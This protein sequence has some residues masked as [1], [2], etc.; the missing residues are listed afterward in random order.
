[1][2]GSKMRP[3]PVILRIT[4]DLQQ[5]LENILFRRYPRGEWGTFFFF[6][7][8]RT[9]TALV[10]TVSDLF[11][12]GAD[13]LDS[14]VPI[15]RFREP[16]IVRAAM[17]AQSGQLGVG[18]IHSHPEDYGVLPSPTDNDMDNYYADYFSGFTKKSC[19][20][21][22]IFSKNK[23][24]CLAISGRGWIDGRPCNLSEYIVPGTRSTRRHH[25]P[26]ES[27]TDHFRKRFI[28]LLGQNSAERLRNSTVVIE[29]CSGTGSPAAHI[30]ARAGVG[31]FVLIDPQRLEASNVER[32]H[33]SSPSQFV[34]GDPPYKVES[35]RE[36]IKQ[37]N[38]DAEVI[39]IVGNILQDL[40][41][42]HAITGDLIIGCTDSHHGRAAL[43]ELAYRYLTPSIDVGVKLEGDAGRVTAEVGQITIYAAG[44]PCAHCLAVVNGRRVTY[45]LMSESERDERR[46]LAAA[47]RARGD[48]EGGYW[49]DFPELHTVGHLA[50][51]GGA[52]AASYAIGWLTGKFQAPDQYFQFNILAAGFDYVPVRLDRKA[53]CPCS[54]TI[55]HADQGAAYS[56]ISPPE[57][58]P[59]AFLLN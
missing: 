37:V 45:E 1:M 58:W 36:L 52:L 39:C 6:G 10:I 32:V 41:R 54:H 33:G 35:L 12:P 44:L 50:T 42:D 31:K 2:V 46:R 15:V 7:F 38:P 8:R 16:Y 20:F 53:G 11:T 43:G 28:S 25:S 30:L 3:L 24:G 51:M 59:R 48:E 14:S 57:H 4:E 17:V 9:R 13:D 18:V 40:A 19:Y 47:A 23:K 5:A 22:L 49:V 55:G 21:S 29:G 26:V 56:I 27:R 34:N